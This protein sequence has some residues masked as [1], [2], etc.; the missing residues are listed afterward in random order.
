M[1]FSKL[2]CFLS[3]IVLFS[4]SKNDDLEVNSF[5]NGLIT[6]PKSFEPN[7]DGI[8]DTFF[9]T[10]PNLY[11]YKIKIFNSRNVIV[12]ESINQYRGWNGDYLGEPVPVGTYT[13]IL[14]FVLTPTDDE[15][16]VSGSV[17]LTR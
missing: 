7:G 1:K 8:N 16:V 4:C 11:K 14:N 17:V 3:F 9:V 15:E 12:F 5:A 13:W 10:A 6:V 2:I